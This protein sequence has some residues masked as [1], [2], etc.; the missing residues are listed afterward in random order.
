VE[1]SKRESGREP[2]SKEQPEPVSEEEA[3]KR[4]L[5]RWELG[6]WLEQQY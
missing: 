1:A 5:G 4:A 2:V 3:G 6:L